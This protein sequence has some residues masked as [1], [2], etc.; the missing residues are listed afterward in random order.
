MQWLAENFIKKNGLRNWTWKRII[1]GII[2]ENIRSIKKDRLKNDIE[3]N[4]IELLWHTFL[5]VSGITKL[6]IV[7]ITDDPEHQDVKAIIF[8]Y[9]LDCFLY[10]RLNKISRDK[11]SSAIDTLG[12]FAVALT[13]IINS[14]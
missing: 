1:N 6:H 7:P 3:L 8:M 2:K 14:V 5:K 12:P 13:K 9:S 10:T 11:D 4:F